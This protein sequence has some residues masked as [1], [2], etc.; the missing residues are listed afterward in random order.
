MS[1][2][3]EFQKYIFSDGKQVISRNKQLFNCLEKRE[4]QKSCY[5]QSF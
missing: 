1:I 3:N 4:G 5:Y 2:E